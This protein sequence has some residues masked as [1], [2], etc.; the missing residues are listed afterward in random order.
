LQV[1]AVQF[2]EVNPAWI[3]GSVPLYCIDAGI[4]ISVVQVFDKGSVDI[5]YIDVNIGLPR[6][7]KFNGRHWIKGIGIAAEQR[8]FSRKWGLWFI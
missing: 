3:T 1:S 8:M 2:H 6:Q 7:I 4:T 5:V